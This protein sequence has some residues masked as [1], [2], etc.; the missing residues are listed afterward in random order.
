M[1]SGKVSNSIL[2]RSVLKLINNKSK[3]ILAG[4]GIGIDCGVVEGK[5]NSNVAIATSNAKY[6]VYRVVNNLSAAGAEGI[7]I[8]DTII[9]PN[10]FDEKV[11]KSIVRDVQEYCRNLN[12]GIVSG[13]TQVS[14]A[15]VKPVI[16][17]T[18]IGYIP[19]EIEISPKNIRPNQ[20]IILTKWI[21]IEGTRIIYDNKKDDIL[22]VY[23]E[24]FLEQA[25]GDLSELS[26]VK[27]ARIAMEFGVNYMHDVAEGG[28]FGALWDMAEA[29]NVGLNINFKKIPVKQE[30]IELCELFDKNPYE[31]ASS[32]CLLITHENGSDLVQVLKDNGIS[33]VVIG[34]TTDGND[35]IIY[36][37]DEK[38]FLEPPKRDEIYTI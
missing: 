3:G 30:I 12:I 2:K 28:I 36:N 37:E 7:A 25:V 18:G 31:L 32:G 20:D 13:H 9:M 24:A 34:K 8:T 33:A 14:E 6:G 19:K 29:G 38:R 17:L 26:V 35:K 11:L 16:S 22:E 4:P 10:D 5:E 15:V 21:G 1:K 27:E 23:T